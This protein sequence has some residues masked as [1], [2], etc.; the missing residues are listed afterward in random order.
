MH[1]VIPFGHSPWITCWSGVNKL[2]QANALQTEALS[3]VGTT[4]GEWRLERLLGFG[5][6]A[7]VYMATSGSKRVA[8][9]TLHATKQQSPKMRAR[10]QREAEVTRSIDSP[11]VIRVH[12]IASS[13]RDELYI[14]MELL[15]GVSLQRFLSQ[16]GGKLN[17]RGALVLAER[18]LTGLAAAHR[19]GIVHRDIKPANI[20]MTRSREVKL[21]DFGVARVEV[22]DQKLTMDGAILGTPAYM[23]P[24]QARGRLDLLDERSDIFAV[25]AVIFQAITGRTIHVANSAEE[26]L[27]M[28][29][30][31]PAPSLAEFA[32]DLP[33]QVIALID[34]SLSWN[35][36]RRFADAIQ[37]LAA[38]S[39][40]RTQAG[41]TRSP[42][43]REVDARKAGAMLEQTATPTIEEPSGDERAELSSFIRGVEAAFISVERALDT[44]RRYGWSHGEVKAVIERALDALL[45]AIA[46]APD[47]VVFKLKP[48]SFVYQ[49]HQVWE[50]KEPFD[51]I[52][53]NLFA[54]GIRRLE[55]EPGMKLDEFE[56]LLRI[57]SLDPKTDLP[58][59][60]DLA[61]VLWE[62]D[63]AHIKLHMVSTFRMDDP[64]DQEAF[65]NE[66]TEQRA[67]VDINLEGR[68]L[69]ELQ[70]TQLLLSMGREA[71]AQARGLAHASG[72]QPDQTSSRV[73]GVLTQRELRSL[74]AALNNTRAVDKQLPFVLA[75]AYAETLA[76]KDAA[77][78][79]EKLA[80]FVAR[81]VRR[82]QFAPLLRTY[83]RLCV[84]LQDRSQ[85]ER[86]TARLFANKAFVERLLMSLATQL[87]VQ[88]NHAPFG[89]PQFI[90]HLTELLTNLGAE[91]GDTIARAYVMFR[92]RKDLVRL[93][94]AFL[95]RHT[96]RN[97]EA[98]GQII[99]QVS[100]R[101]AR[102]LVD[103]L[104]AD[105][106]PDATTALRHANKHPDDKLKLDLLAW[107]A[108]QDPTLV[109]PQVEELA[110]TASPE[111]RVRALQIALQHEVKG[112]AD[113]AADRI[114][115]DAF[116]KLPYSERR[117]L[118]SLIGQQDQRRA[119]ELA[120]SILSSHGLAPDPVR[121]TTRILAVELLGQMPTTGATL[122]AMETAARKRPWNSKELQQ[123][124]SAALKRHRGT[125]S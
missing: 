23:P 77:A 26:A 62:A 121:D 61:T 25:G 118:F 101:H 56:Q 125:R 92:D 105:G 47:R 27:I 7:A 79:E 103:L 75:D 22:S 46:E 124:A 39:E 30:T 36:Q 66:C 84:C 99:P 87:E 1:A 70:R 5:G 104:K 45:D 31:R 110:S 76:R 35:P 119:F 41:S 53:Y 74:T 54:S 50:P 9:K 3:R 69:V 120:V 18:L 78:F 40:C 57:F 13:A 32:P 38:T 86:L 52:P 20:F 4:L 60:D 29:A 122:E 49:D 34:T 100:L 67:R 14:V 85:R 11:N 109:R 83:A 6:A 107:R 102:I 72:N 2:S 114:D 108:G 16:Q 96:Q 17:H 24:E 10:F 98:I 123:A 97:E 82:E 90:E 58:P 68:K 73:S 80:D 91:H 43:P 81:H 63:L 88:P 51:N 117:M 115:H 106:G 94:Y 12:D 93:C 19:L 71:L 55:L 28:A 44:I 8:L 15:E 59:E 113:F 48:Y 64:D 42:A 65:M 21:L 37:M 33:E 89:D 95:R 112:L 116:Y 111:L